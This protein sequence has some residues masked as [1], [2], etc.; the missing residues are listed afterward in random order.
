MTDDLR[1]LVI[2]TDERL[3]S[4]REESL[5]SAMAQG[6]RIGALEAE[7]TSLKSKLDV[8]TGDGREL[9]ASLRVLKVLGLLS[10]AAALGAWFKKL[11]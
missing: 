3:R 11:L 2:R 9:R 4:L 6:Q 10:L 7:V 5:R 8:E 1:E